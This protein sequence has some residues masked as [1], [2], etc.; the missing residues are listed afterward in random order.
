M[1]LSGEKVILRA[2]ELSDKDIL[3]NMIND[4]EMEYLLGGW[5]FPVSDMKQEEWIKSIDS[6]PYVLRCMIDDKQEHSTAGTV[7]LSDID[8]INGTAEIHIKLLKSFRGK[9]F[10]TDTIKTMVRYAFSE[11]RLQC[12]YAHINDYNIGSHKLFEKSGFIKEG[13]LRSRIYKNGTYHNLFVYSILKEE[14]YGNRE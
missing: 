6:E 5:S 8:Y 11:L 2:I 3:R 14:S 10:G 4:G 1:F 7:I 9:G 13:V 12:I